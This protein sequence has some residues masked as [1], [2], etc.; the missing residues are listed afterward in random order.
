MWVAK[1]L[2]E[3][4]GGVVW[5]QDDWG[6]TANG[7]V[8][9]GPSPQGLYLIATSRLAH[10][11]PGAGLD[12]RTAGPHGQWVSASIFGCPSSGPIEFL[13]VTLP[14]Q[15]PVLQLVAVI[16]PGGFQAAMLGY[17]FSPDNGG[18]ISS[19]PYLGYIVIQ[20]ARSITR[21][22]VNQG[23]PAL[24]QAGAQSAQSVVQ[25]TQDAPTGGQRDRAG[26]WVPYGKPILDGDNRV[27]GMETS[28]TTAVTAKELAAA[29][30][31]AVHSFSTGHC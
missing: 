5:I 8:V 14:V 3:A 29:L 2:P 15:I 27:I 20:E 13:Y 30:L 21:A 6:T 11:T 23:P 16:P 31:T 24:P 12:V 28:G 17:W 25:F 1:T 19:D 26:N 18:T 9:G 10:L 7:F 4:A 22:P